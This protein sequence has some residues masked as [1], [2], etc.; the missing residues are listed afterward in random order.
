MK[1]AKNIKGVPFMNCNDF[2]F[3]GNIF[4]LFLNFVVAKMVH[5]FSKINK[6]FYFNI[7]L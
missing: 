3:W 6:G 4:L 5:K 7:C 2:L 1:D